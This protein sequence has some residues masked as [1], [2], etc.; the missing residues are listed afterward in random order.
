[1]TQEELRYI[2]V[3]YRK[4]QRNKEQLRYLREKATSVSLPPPEAEKV[5]TSSANRSN[6][7][8]D[9]A[10]DLEREIAAMELRLV[11]LQEKVSALIKELD[12]PLE[13]KVLRL[14]YLKCLT[15]LQVAELSGYADRHVRRINNE[16]IDGLEEK[17]EC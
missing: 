1:M 3:L 13:Q 11:H 16:I 14:R 15:W 12:N 9:E 4:I 8:A 7:Y 10:V 6:K 5:K 17:I 2:P